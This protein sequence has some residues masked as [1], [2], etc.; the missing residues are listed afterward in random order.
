SHQDRSSSRKSASFSQA[1]LSDVVIHE[2]G[3]MARAATSCI[4]DMRGTA[5]FRRHLSGVLTR[6]VLAQAIE[7]A[8]A[9]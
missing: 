6:R 3:D 9:N 4:S 7:R 8:K 5:D 1:R 2:A